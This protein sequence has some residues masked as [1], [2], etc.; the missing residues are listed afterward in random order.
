M[1]RKIRVLKIFILTECKIY[2][3]TG[4]SNFQINTSSNFSIFINKK[5][6]LYD[7]EKKKIRIFRKVSCFVSFI[8]C[9]FV[10]V[11]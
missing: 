10:N 7:Y 2:Y 8:S 6:H 9:H 1:W 5:L 3:K 4:I 11:T